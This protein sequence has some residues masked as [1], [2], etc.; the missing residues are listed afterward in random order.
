MLVN[1]LSDVDCQE[2]EASGKLEV[3]QSELQNI[4]RK[5]GSFQLPGA[6][7]VVSDLRQSGSLSLLTA[8]DPPLFQS[9][10][11]A[12]RCS[13]AEKEW[14]HGVGTQYDAVLKFKV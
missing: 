14:R 12:W 9:Q 11:L 8:V 6:P 4:A 3:L 1:Q 2:L 7:S 10:Q 13:D 5:Y